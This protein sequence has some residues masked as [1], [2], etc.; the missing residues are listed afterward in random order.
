MRK[1]KLDRRLLLTADTI[2]LKK[3]V[4]SSVVRRHCGGDIKSSYSMVRVK[5]FP[6]LNKNSP[7]SLIGKTLSLLSSIIFTYVQTSINPKSRLW[8]SVSAVIKSLV[9]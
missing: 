9:Q 7:R 2:R 3:N 6:S 8:G 4:I 1:G 5:G